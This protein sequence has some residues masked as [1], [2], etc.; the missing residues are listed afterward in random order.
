MLPKKETA[1]LTSSFLLHLISK[2]DYSS[3]GEEG[4][5]EKK[6]AIISNQGRRRERAVT[7][8]GGG[9]EFDSLTSLAKKWLG[10]E[11]GATKAKKE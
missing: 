4:R 1:S 6:L 5:R 8:S 9:P 2:T 7:P 3:R 10:K 11:D